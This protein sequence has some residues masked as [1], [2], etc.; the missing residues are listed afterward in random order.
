MSIKQGQHIDGIRTL[1]DLRGR[2]VI[3]EITGCWHLRTPRG[4]PQPKGETAY[5]WL[6]GRGMTTCLRAFWEL[7]HGAPVP[8]GRIAFR[9]CGSYDC[10]CHLRV[11]TR[12]EYGVFCAKSGRLKMTPQRLAKAKAASSKRT[13]ITDEQVQW[14]LGS[15]VTE[16]AAAKALGCSASLI[17]HIRAG[18]KRR[19]SLPASVFDWMPA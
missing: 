7:S 9:T 18:R 6:H 4:K 13:K 11:G 8:G 12:S 2:C 3:D 10:V 5:V 16:R 1:E 14:I 15:D 19:P 17:G